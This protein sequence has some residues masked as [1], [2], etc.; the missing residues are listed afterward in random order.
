MLDIYSIIFLEI[1]QGKI[2][3]SKKYKCEVVIIN[4]KV[5]KKHKVID[6]LKTNKKL[7]EIYNEFC[8]N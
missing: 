2:F 3:Y 4:D 1:L 8:N 7:L 6:S 5:F